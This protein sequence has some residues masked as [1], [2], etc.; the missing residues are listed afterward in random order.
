MN[1]CCIIKKIMFKKLLLSFFVFLTTVLTSVLTFFPTDDA[2]V[3][4]NNP[5][6]NFGTV[7]TLQADTSPVKNFFLKS[8]PTPPNIKEIVDG[9][10]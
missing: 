2:Y 6:K 8:Q 7:V 10:I 5:N 1:T 3:N 4:A 9:Q